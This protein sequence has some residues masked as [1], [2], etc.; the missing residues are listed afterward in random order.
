MPAPARRFAALFALALAVFA[1]LPC[2]SL[3][4]GDTCCGA[5]RGCAT[6]EP[7]PCAQLAAGA[8]CEDA[9]IPVDAPAASPQPVPPALAPLLGP[10]P[11]LTRAPRTLLP[12]AFALADALALR[13]VI[14]R[15]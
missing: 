1:A 14:L 9:G 10:A 5:K 6:E 8:C 3:A 2:A 13:T 15:L 11:S 12:P 4:A 7:A